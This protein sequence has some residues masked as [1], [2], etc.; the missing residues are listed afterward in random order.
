M[1]FSPKMHLNYAPHYNYLL[2]IIVLSWLAYLNFCG[3]L[4][5]FRIKPLSFFKKKTVSSYFF[6]PMFDH[7]YK[8]ITTSLNCW[9]MNYFH[10]IETNGKSNDSFYSTIG[11]ILSRLR[12]NIYYGS[13]L[14]TPPI[15]FSSRALARVRARRR[16]SSTC[17]RIHVIDVTR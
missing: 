11:S 8:I 1:R 2:V 7:T 10:T 17:S 14:E 9:K 6:I 13:K 4:G 3:H 16:R 12:G 15:D 5:I